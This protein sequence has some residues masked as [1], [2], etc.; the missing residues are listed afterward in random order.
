MTDAEDRLGSLFA[1]DLP[2]ARDGA[3]HAEVLAALARRRFVDEIGLLAA[4]SVIGAVALAVVWPWLAPVLASLGQDLAPA[5]I[6][7]VMVVSI[8]GLTVGGEQRER[9]ADA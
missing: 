6:A 9:Q 2:P 7:L 4:M 5:A 3:F 1:A 8:L